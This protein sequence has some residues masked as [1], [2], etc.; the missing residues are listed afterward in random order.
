ML[1][2]QLVGSYWLADHRR[3]IMFNIGC[4]LLLA[5]AIIFPVAV[6]S[7]LAA[8]ASIAA[9][10]VGFGSGAL[11]FAIL[12]ALGDASSELTKGLEG[13]VFGMFAATT[14]LALGVGIL[15]IAGFLSL[16]DYRD[17]Q[18]M[19]LLIPM[20][21]GPAIAGAVGLMV[22]RHIGSDRP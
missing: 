13:P 14:K 2:S 3:D 1:V 22:S 6:F 15:M 17:T 12:T 11:G 18:N 20:V 4:A 10:A 7:K 5:G 16:I 8:V 21:L 9:A 19:A